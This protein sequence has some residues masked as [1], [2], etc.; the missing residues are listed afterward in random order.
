MF[1]KIQI[2]I[3]GPA[4]SGKSV[5]GHLLS[6]KLD[7]LFLDTGLMY[8]AATKIISDHNLLLDDLE[9]IKLLIKDSTFEL[10]D[11]SGH[12]RLLVNSKD[13][14]DSLKTIQIDRN[15]STI[16][17]IPE[18]RNILVS[19][20][21]TIASNDNIV[22]VGRD[23]GS[24]VLPNANLKIYLDASVEVRAKRRL[25]DKKQNFSP[26]D[27]DIIKHDLIQRDKTDSTREHSPLM[28]PKGSIVIDTSD[29]NI[30][31]VIESI[32]KELKN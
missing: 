9:N 19:H 29:L 6:K 7:Y 10:V 32:L 25:N 22:M 26:N 1:T 18:V 4:A 8:R 13:L 24:I 28:I 20:Q 30:S 5:V 2:A 12:P 14:T 17:K 15:V 27:F 23:I 11:N 16:S 3:D 21:R 31:E